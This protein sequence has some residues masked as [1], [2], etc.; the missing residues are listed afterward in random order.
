MRKAWV[1]GLCA[2]IGLCVVLAVA[3]AVVGS[4]FDEARL[5]Q[6]DLSSELDELET[7][8]EL[9]RRERTT[10][11]SERETLQGERDQYKSQMDDQLKAIEQLKVELER[12]RQ[13]G[14]AGTPET[15]A[16]GS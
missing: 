13:A 1:I 15:P 5:E 4:R 10:M 16:A 7:E 3:L 2:S 14:A 8:N 11:Q 9:L 6:E 12:A